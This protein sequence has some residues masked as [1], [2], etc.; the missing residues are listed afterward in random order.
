MTLRP[1]GG[2]FHYQ[3]RL[4]RIP[5]L[6]RILRREELSAADREIAEGALR[7]LREAVRMFEEAARRAT[8]R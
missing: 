4:E 1:T 7:E 5:N 2:V 6:Q 8:Q 3:K